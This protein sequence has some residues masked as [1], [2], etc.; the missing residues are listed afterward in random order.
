MTPKKT[1]LPLSSLQ[2]N[3]DDWF[4]NIR[5]HLM[6]CGDWHKKRDLFINVREEPIR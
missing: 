5:K 3:G 2:S 1:H 6:P 4:V